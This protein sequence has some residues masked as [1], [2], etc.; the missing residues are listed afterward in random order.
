MVLECGRHGLG[1]GACDLE[2]DAG[3]GITVN[4]LR[5]VLDISYRTNI[6]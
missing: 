5:G 6:R 1:S 3:P 4:E 2:C